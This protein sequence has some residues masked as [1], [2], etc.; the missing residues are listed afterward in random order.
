MNIS[1]SYQEMFPNNYANNYMYTIFKI[2]YTTMPYKTH[3]RNLLRFI[4]IQRPESFGEKDT[5]LAAVNAKTKIFSRFI[6]TDPLIYSREEYYSP[7]K[8]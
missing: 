4:Y 3:A 7:E 1:A 6:Y 2:I 8:Y 5:K